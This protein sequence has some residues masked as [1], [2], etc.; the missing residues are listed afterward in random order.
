ME[1]R[2]VNRDEVPHTPKRKMTITRALAELKN[3]RS[4]ISS[5]EKELLKYTGAIFKDGFTILDGMISEKEFISRYENLSKEL[6]DLN[7]NYRNIKL[8]LA[9]ANVEIKITVEG[10]TLT[11]NEAIVLKEQLESQKHAL[12]ATV[13]KLAELS[14]KFKSKEDDNT[15]YFNNLFELVTTTTSYELFE[16][17]S[18]IDRIINEINITLVEVNS[19]TYI[20]V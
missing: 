5:T 20:E 14:N 12:D 4:K 2:K 17:R 19:S 11:I 1:R 7:N 15:E 6:R 9:K 18:E 3:I 16:R 8:E 10:R 13:N